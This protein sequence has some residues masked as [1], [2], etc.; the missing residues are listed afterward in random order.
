[1]KPRNTRIKVVEKTDGHATW[2]TYIPQH[3][4][5]FGFWYD[6]SDWDG[7]NAF[8][9]TNPYT[10]RLRGNS[11]SSAKEQIDGYIEAFEKEEIRRKGKDIVNVEY[12][13]YP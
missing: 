4:N 9:H 8:C 2:K 6:F 11:L 13:K 12:I 3:Q 5:F 10:C 1:M 7:Y